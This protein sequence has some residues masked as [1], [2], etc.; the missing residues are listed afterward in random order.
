[1]NLEPYIVASPK[2]DSLEFEVR[3]K[4]YNDCG[5]EISITLAKIDSADEVVRF[6][7]Y[8]KGGSRHG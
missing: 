6:L 7:H 5:E 8:L 2:G 1:M 3:L 4:T